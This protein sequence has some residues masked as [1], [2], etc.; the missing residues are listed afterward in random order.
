MALKFSETS[1]K[2][3]L[4]ELKINEFMTG[5]NNVRFGSLAVIATD[6]DFKVTPY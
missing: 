1:K 4:A 6:L 2:L 5:A 3:R